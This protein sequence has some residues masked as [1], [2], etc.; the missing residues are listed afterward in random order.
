ML[1]AR[2]RKARTEA[3]VFTEQ[4]LRYADTPIRLPLFGAFGERLETGNKRLTN[5]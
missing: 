1:D 3:T 5:D 2:K 4:K